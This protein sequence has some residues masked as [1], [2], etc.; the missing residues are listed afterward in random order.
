MLNISNNKVSENINIK[1]F[2]SGQEIFSKQYHKGF[3]RFLFYFSIILVVIL[4]LPWTQN[5]TSNGNVTT[6]KPN[7]RPQTLQ[8]QIPGRIEEWFV[9]EGDFVKKGDTIIR[10]SEV[11]SDYFDERLAERTDN[12]L[13]AKSSSVEAYKNK[14]I[15]SR[16]QIL[17][18]QQERALKLKQAK[19]KLIQTRLKVKTDSMD[20]EAIKIKAKIAKTQY[21]RTVSLHEEGLKAVKDVEEKSAKLQEAEAKLISQQNKYLSTQNEVINSQLSISTISATYGDKL[22]KAQSNLFTAQSSGFDTEAEV[23]KLET[24]L[25]NYKK[26]NSLLYVTAPQD[27]FINKA[28]K[29]GV[30]ETFKEGEQLVNI[31][32][33]N[34]DLAIEMYI[35]PID[36]PLIHTNENVRVQFDGWPAIVFSGWPN[37]SYGTYGAK[38]VA[39]EN[40]ISNNGKYRVL[41]APDKNDVNW[42]EAIR[43]GSGAKT[44]ALLDNVPIWFELWRLINSFPPNFYQPN[45][46][47]K[48]SNN[49]KKA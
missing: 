9:Q 47:T 41:L 43:V 37:V 22:A 1:S 13:T 23:S 14:V 36:L 49:K 4:F 30:G 25:A 24:N 31:M 15:A 28:I 21:N 35:R 17:A 20:L 34:Y 12:Q 33:S 46:N 19:N 44:V 32:P 18:L 3:K 38:V 29:S 48:Y 39:I 40:F 16:N 42:P 5:I 11:K 45:N 7:Q 6:L 2:K 26:R 8:S 27:G 10:I